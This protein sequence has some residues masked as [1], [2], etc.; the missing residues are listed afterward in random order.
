MRPLATP[1][2][3]LSNCLAVTSFQPP[4]P[5]GTLNKTTFGVSAAKRKTFSELFASSGMV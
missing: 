2:T 5:S 3:A 4:L 1:V